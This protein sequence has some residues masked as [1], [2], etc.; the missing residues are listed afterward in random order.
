MVSPDDF[1]RL[2]RYMAGDLSPEETHALELELA[3]D[4]ALREALGQLKLL[5]SVARDLPR[6]SLTESA[7]EQLVAR[8]LHPTR[9]TWVRPALGL[10][11]VLVALLVGWW[12]VRAG[13]ASGTPRL[14]AVIAEALLDGR[15]ASV[16]DLVASGS[17]IS[18]GEHALASINQRFM[19]APSSELQLTAP[20]AAVL[21]RGA[22]SASG[23]GLRVT[24]DD[25]TFI[26][27]GE[28]LLS[29]EPFE[30]TSRETA[31]LTPEQLVNLKRVTVGSV[32][33][34][35][36]AVAL[37][38][39]SGSVA[40]E[41]VGA[42]SQV[43]RAPKRWFANGRPVTA[44]RAPL[45]D[46][47]LTLASAVAQSFDGLLE[48]HVTAGGKPV[49][50]ASVKLYEGARVNRI[51]NR[52]EWPVSREGGTTNDAGVLLIGADP[53]A[54]LAA[55]RANGWPVS[56]H[57]IQRPTGQWRTQVDIVLEPGVTL[58]GFTED[59]R[60]HQPVVPAVVT[61]R[62]RGT[63]EAEWVSV[64]VDAHGRFSVESLTAGA[65]IG[66]AVSP[67]AGK[68]TFGTHVPQAE[69]LKLLFHGS[70]FVEGFVRY[71]DGGVAAGARVVLVGA[72]TLEAE[73]SASGSFSLEAAAGTWRAQATL[74]STVGAA[75]VEARVHAGETTSVGEIVLRGSTSLSGRVTS[76]DAGV[77]KAV[78]TV[79][80][81]GGIG[82]IARTQA[83][84]SGR[85]S[86]LLAPGVYDVDADSLELGTVAESGVHVGQH[87]TTLDLAIP[88]MGSIVGT[89]ADGEGNLLDGAL[90]EV[91]P[92]WN[93]QRAR[94]IVSVAGKF[95]FHDVVP[96]L[97]TVSRQ[98]SGQSA[99]ISKLVN[100]APGKASEVA[101][102]IADPVVIEGKVVWKCAGPPRLLAVNAFPF[103]Q[104]IVTGPATHRMSPGQTQFRLELA[105]GKYTLFGSTGD[106]SCSG[107][108]VVS[109]EERSKPVVLEMVPNK[110][111]FEV[112]VK[113]ADGHPAGGAML[114]LRSDDSGSSSV[115]IQTE[116][117]GVWQMRGDQTHDR[118]RLQSVSAGKDGRIASSGPIAPAT[119]AITLTL[120]T[121][122][123][124]EVQ[125]QGVVE[126]S[127]SSLELVSM[128]SFV[129]ADSFVTTSQSIRLEAVPEG[130]LH[131][132][133]RNG[134]LAGEGEVVIKRGEAAKLSIRLLPGGSVRGRLVNASGQ[135]VSGWV[136]L[137][138]ES[139]EEGTEGTTVDDSGFFVI[140]PVSA[141]R[142]ALKV[143][144]EA[145]TSPVVV[146]SGEETL[147]GDIVVKHDAR[148][149]E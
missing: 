114:S 77:E 36:G 10:A 30:G 142:Y 99:E 60:T 118:R 31:A 53:G 134:A 146:K 98:R 5:D 15:A 9:S 22:L 149:D 6:A 93:R 130:R 86:V 50:N 58:T 82:E 88:P 85:Y 16:G 120:G 137:L 35:G 80:P 94:T 2:A 135:P 13:P 78:V 1:E 139:G 43:V 126:G 7:V 147:A 91:Y 42:E 51:I 3:G 121:S 84:Q 109:T 26:V 14:T 41:Q 47:G 125:L 83:D 62:R 75:R 25:R 57:D 136:G 20:D 111:L 48:I 65:Y 40:I 27:T 100:V 37:W 39:L 96:G 101:L 110:V 148:P 74:G 73:A 105:R 54:Y 17:I 8:A 4:P 141:G 97:Q 87:E 69:P 127:L 76:G 138:T 23:E 79:T 56:L 123:A 132:T 108:L 117:D 45:D 102:V 18:T 67:G 44:E 11:A 144:G 21:R 112:T 63:P 89:V 46:G 92:Q 131:V 128:P 68:A 34:I 115:M 24:L 61:V 95:E 19:V 103:Q 38:V 90:I 12:L 32:A 145:S 119:K 81:H 143:Y 33:V 133:A 71:P 28:A 55:V 129:F 52:I 124:L 59:A 113:E 107:H 66:E 106:D 64:D 29:R 122:Q 70:G 49:A 72:D 140:Q 104:S 116:E